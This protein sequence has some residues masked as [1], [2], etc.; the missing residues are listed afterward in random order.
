MITKDS[1]GGLIEVEVFTSV[2]QM[3]SDH[4][5]KAFPIPVSEKL[6]A[7]RCGWTLPT[8]IDGGLPLEG[9][10]QSGEVT[11]C[12]EYMP[13]GGMMLCYKGMKVALEG[14]HH[15]QN[16]WLDLFNCELEIK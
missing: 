9:M 14:L 5:I 10:M 2:L 7:D 12:R 1:S 13:N 8:V 3:I 15:L 6:L 11:V 16:L 4:S